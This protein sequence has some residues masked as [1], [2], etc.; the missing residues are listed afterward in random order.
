MTCGRF[1]AK[2]ALVAGASDLAEAICHRLAS[3]GAAI[4]VVDSSYERARA[5]AETLPGAARALHLDSSDADAWR[6]G[7]RDL[8][9][10]CGGLDLMVNCA[11]CVADDRSP[12]FVLRDLRRARRQSVDATFYACRAAVGAMPD[13]GAIITVVPS[14]LLDGSERA[15]VSAT[16][17]GSLQGLTRDVAVYCARQ[18]YGIRCNLVVVGS[19]ANADTAGERVAGL[20]AFLGSEQAAFVTGAEVE[21]G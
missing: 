15:I 11:P 8:A 19:T 3:E 21:C 1:E 7:V 5:V 12:T 2:T 4:C 13:G 18:G 6:A 14:P 10:D 9:A 17:L 16:A 20:V